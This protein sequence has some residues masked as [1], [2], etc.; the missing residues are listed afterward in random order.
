MRFILLQDLR[1]K[2]ISDSIALENSHIYL[3]I[4]KQTGNIESL[5]LK[6]Q[7]IEFFNTEGNKIVIGYDSPKTMYQTWNLDRN[8]MKNK[9]FLTKP[10]DIKI[11][12]DG[13]LRKTI[14]IYNSDDVSGSKV[15]RFVT[16]YKGSSKV[17]LSYYLDS[18][19]KKEV[20]KV[21]FPFNSKDYLMRCGIPY[22]DIIRKPI[23]PKGISEME[24]AKWEFPAQL[25]VNA[26][27]H[28]KNLSIFTYDKFGWSANQKALYLTLLRTPIMVQSMIYNYS[29]RVEKRQ[30][31]TD[32]GPHFI[33]ICLDLK[34][35]QQN[36]KL[37]NDALK[38]N[39][40]PLEI[41]SIL[42]KNTFKFET[43]ATDQPNKNNSSLI[44]CSNPNIIISVLK[45]HEDEE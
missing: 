43:P 35:N 12:E 37:V 26:F 42:K 28:E 38:F 10:E 22:G 14:A 45:F 41:I 23:K 9:R 13:L 29:R 6:G 33:E 32:Q 31:W 25:F 15:I 39:Y 1:I 11:I 8:W 5:L 2:N 21:K 4:S 18:R 34:A 7:N 17:Y 3:E 19:W 44:E 27:D 24:A 30:K 16:L 20:I 36:P 40:R